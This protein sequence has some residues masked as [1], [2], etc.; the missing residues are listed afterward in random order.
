VGHREADG[1]PPGAPPG[2]F[3]GDGAHF[4]RN[5]G[6]SGP[7][8]LTLPATSRYDPGMSSRNNR[9][10]KKANHGKRPANRNRRAARSKKFKN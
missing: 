4:G 2:G 6:G 7:V 5:R 10:V 1:A 8:L 3:S 9:K